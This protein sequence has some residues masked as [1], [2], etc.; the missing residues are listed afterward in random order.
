MSE[1]KDF[2]FEVAALADDSDIEKIVYQVSEY[3]PADWLKATKKAAKKGPDELGYVQRVLE[4]YNIK[5]DDRTGYYLYN[6]KGLGA[7]H[8][9][10]NSR[11]YHSC[12][13][14]KMHL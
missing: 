11:P 2:L 9:E 5:Y 14:Q 10:R 4:L 13:W 3:F 6:K 12:H 7:H 1:F 8:S